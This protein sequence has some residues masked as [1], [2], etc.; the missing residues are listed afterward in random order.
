MRLAFIAV[1]RIVEEKAASDEAYREGLRKKGKVVL[2]DGRALSD[3]ELLAKLASVGLA[4]DRARFLRGT[5]S[6]VSAEEMAEAVYDH[7]AL[8]IPD[9]DQD[10]VWIAFTCLWERWSPERPSLEM[11]DDA[12]QAGYQA[13]AAGDTPR[14]CRLWLQTWRWIR[15]VM[16]ARDVRSMA[17]WDEQYCGTQSLFNWCQVFKRALGDAGRKDRQFLEERL[18]VIEA[19]LRLRPRDGRLRDNCR[20]DLA[21]TYFNLGMP[22]K[23]E[24]LFRQWLQKRPTWGWG[25]IHWADCYYPFTFGREKDP[26]RAEQIL[27]QGLAV[28]GVE[29]Q[30]HLLERLKGV[31]EELGRPEEAKA[32]QAEIDRHRKPAPAPLKPPQ[33]TRPEERG[34]RNPGLLPSAPPRGP[35]PQFG[36]PVPPLA[37]VGRNDPCPC[38]SGKKFKNCCLRSQRAGD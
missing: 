3:D 10:W 17:E 16:E 19:L 21:E 38:G 15:G 24:Q 8:K 14:A 31:Y 7:P 13:E 34:P 30:V 28:P 27:K 35:L 22:E 20:S 33:P 5:E 36:R 11:I 37:R 12:M 2:A 9:A 23:G 25:W 18:E 1:N 4:L 6:F 26:T 32:A 29:E